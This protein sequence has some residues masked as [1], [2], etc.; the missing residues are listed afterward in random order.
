MDRR[1]KSSLIRKWIIRPDRGCSSR[2]MS[3][4]EAIIS[5]KLDRWT[6][7]TSNTTSREARLINI[8]CAITRRIS[9]QQTTKNWPKVVDSS[10]SKLRCKVTRLKTAS[11][12]SLECRTDLA[13]LI[14]SPNNRSNPSGVHTTSMRRCVLR[15]GKLPYSSPVKS[16]WVV[17]HKISSSCSRMSSRGVPEVLN[18]HAPDHNKIAGL[19]ILMKTC[20]NMLLHPKTLKWS[21]SSEANKLRRRWGTFKRNCSKTLL[22]PRTL[23][24]G[25]N[26]LVGMLRKRA[27]PHRIRLIP[28]IRISNHNSSAQVSKAL[29]SWCLKSASSNIRPVNSKLHS[30]AATTSRCLPSLSVYLARGSSK[31]M[32]VSWSMLRWSTQNMVKSRQITLT[33]ASSPSTR[34]RNR[35]EATCSMLIDRNSSTLSKTKNMTPPLCKALVKA[36]AAIRH[37]ASKKLKKLV[38]SRSVIMIDI[39]K[40]QISLRTM[41]NASIEHGIP[42]LQ[43]ARTLASN[44]ELHHLWTL[45]LRMLLASKE[46]SLHQTTPLQT[47]PASN[48]EL[49]HPKVELQRMH[50]ACNWLN[51]SLKLT[52]TLPKSLRLYAARMLLPQPVF[53]S[54]RT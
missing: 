9:T 12:M 26:S 15:I 33:S 16:K 43:P 13:Q 6:P 21:S 31:P 40:P 45:A 37:H 14:N 5:S 17:S 44:N 36:R 50:L 38:K 4:M 30:Q 27:T 42:Q 23:R 32:Q 3:G 52:K 25:N 47:F 10:T 28:S 49:I 2:L 51:S 22:K 54:K 41:I 11:I 7:R 20:S 8:P 24:I 46:H 29:L 1:S 18:P 35:S 53:N 19:C 34:F 48:S 39:K